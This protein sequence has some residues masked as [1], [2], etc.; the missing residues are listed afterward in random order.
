MKRP[1]RPRRQFLMFKQLIRRT[2]KQIL[3]WIP[4]Q[5]RNDKLD[6]IK[7]FMMKKKIGVFTL[8][9]GSFHVAEN[10]KFSLCLDILI[11]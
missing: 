5:A 9:S 10:R 6:N 2:T 1:C 8:K 3:R 4:G 11:L 7:T